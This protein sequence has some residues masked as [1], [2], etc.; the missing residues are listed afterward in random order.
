MREGNPGKKIKFRHI[1]SVVAIIVALTMLVQYFYVLNVRI[2]EA[3]ENS[4]SQFMGQ[5]AHV[6]DA[7]WDSDG[8]RIRE[9]A[10]IISK[11]DN[12]ETIMN[13][14]Q[15]DSTV[16]RYLIVDE[17][18][19]EATASD[20]SLQKKR[21]NHEFTESKVIEGLELSEAF[22][23]KDGGWSY[24]IRCPITY[25]DSKKGWLYAQFLFSRMK[26]MFPSTMYEGY[27]NAFILDKKTENIVFQNDEESY[28]SVTGKN[29]DVFVREVIGGSDKTYEKLNAAIAQNNEA[30]LSETMNGID[31]VMYLAPIGSGDYYFIGIA[32]KQNV[33]SESK[34]VGELFN[35]T[36][37]LVGMLLVG[38]LLVFY[39]Y[40]YKKRTQRDKETARILH[41]S[42]LE[43][44]YEEAKAANLAKSQFL[45]NMS[46]EIRT[47]INAVIGLNEMILRES[48]QPKIEE[49]AH[50]VNDAANVLLQIVNDILDINKIENGEIEILPIEYNLERMFRKLMVVVSGRAEDK[51]LKL[52]LDLDRSL[53]R[54]LRG[55]EAR[56]RQ[57]IMNL[58]T[59][60]IKYTP[61]GM[62]TIK[63]TGSVNADKL[64]FRVE[65]SDTGI[66][67]KE[68]DIPKLTQK[69]TRIEES[70]NRNIAG[71][72]LGINI[73]T[74]LLELMNSKLEIESEYAKGSKFS[75]EIL[76]DIVD[77]DPIEKTTDSQALP[78]KKTVSIDASAAKVMVVD[79]NSMNRKV[80]CELLKITGI[81]IDAVESGYECLELLKENKYDLIFMDH[82]M[83]HMDGV[84]TFKQIRLGNTS[85]QNTP[86]IALTANAIVG[87]KDYYLEIGF[88]DYISKP[89]RF[90]V[91]E[92][93]LI[94]FVRSEKL[95]KIKDS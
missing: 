69:F 91:L 66:G 43:K 90:S 23:S 6:M 17:D 61:A 5:I 62:V 7:T 15:E 9:V 36:Y 71:T 16:Y 50:D 24:L 40:T 4:L 14:M 38:S 31:V 54:V 32:K 29:L 2:D 68:E 94:K 27:G 8:S 45:T 76:Q 20:G 3:A 89:V 56:I 82:M 73:V 57:I 78:N 13:G 22:L 83:P 58:V 65:V 11:T 72:G 21:T 34:I 81:Q 52:K 86:V 70:R 79:D 25:G 77:E 84:E 47:P 63:A 60:A 42:E 12:K 74:E 41:E 18:T 26:S 53:P 95:K 1:F 67:I 44:A 39:I 33:L 28:A 46:H 55:D 75:F 37:I 88:D 51:G 85:N 19:T 10:N 87:A 92:E 35:Y 64:L 80:I 30:V 49:Y 48:T 93:A 59:N